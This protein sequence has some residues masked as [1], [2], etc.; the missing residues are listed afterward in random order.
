M[1][2]LLCLLAFALSPGIA[3]AA[4]TAGPTLA[5]GQARLLRQHS[6]SKGKIAFSYLGDIWLAGENK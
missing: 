2:S 5:Q 6:Y 3:L 4:E 1:K